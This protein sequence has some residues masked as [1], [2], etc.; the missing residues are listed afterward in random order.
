MATNFYFRNFDA[1]REQDLLEDLIIESI[2]IYGF[3]VYYMPRTLVA[4]DEIYTEDPISIYNNAYYVDMYIKNVDGFG[5]E[6][7][8]YSKFN[9]QIRDTVTFTIA[10]RT[11]NQEIAQYA[12]IDRP[13]EGDLIY[14]PLSNAI[15]KITFVEHEPVFY[16][17]GRLNAYDV[18][19]EKFE[20]SSERFNTGIDAIDRVE[21][22]FTLNMAAFA[23][24]D[25][26]GFILTDEDGFPIIQDQFDY[27]KQNFDILADNYEIQNESDQ[28]LDFSSRNPFSENW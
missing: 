9:L 11:F 12:T 5:G 15:F 3:D 13:Q 16:A 7:D 19:C 14:F 10:R 2:K 20:Y 22:D 28:I 24:L 27:E 26:D 18:T 4:E 17:L 25:Q 8:F 6:G 21:R 1:S 23:L